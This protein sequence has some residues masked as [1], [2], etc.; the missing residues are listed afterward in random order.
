M[1]SRKNPTDM[2]FAGIT[3]LAAF[4]VIILITGILY[5]LVRE[6][7]PAIERFGVFGFISGDDWNPVTESFGAATNIFG[8]FVTTLL[9]MTIAIPI[10]IGIAILSPK[11]R[12]IFC[13]DLLEER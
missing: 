1:I 7:W 11:Y 3:G 2:L 8:T 13:R 5:V 6:S 10:A 12:Q 9:S 4:A